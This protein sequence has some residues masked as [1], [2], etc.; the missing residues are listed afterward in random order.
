MGSP[1]VHWEMWSEDPTRVADF[2]KQAFDWDINHIVE[3][4]YHM[5]NTGGK[6][7]INGGIMKPKKG[8]G[9]M[10][11]APRSGS[12]ASTRQPCRTASTQSSAGRPF[13]L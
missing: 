4:D 9:I 11:A 7:G 2:Y 12:S 6:G 5:V 8:P 3:M 10:P 1:V 13:L